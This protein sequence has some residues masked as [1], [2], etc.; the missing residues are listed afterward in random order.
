MFNYEILPEHMQDGM[1]LYIERGIEGGGF[2]TAVLCNDLMGALGKADSI[3][4]HALFDYGNFLY[5][6]APASCYGSPEKVAAWVARG[7]LQGKG[8]APIPTHQPG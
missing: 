8:L 6:E 5:N 2:L 3:N 4:R 7:G 1:R